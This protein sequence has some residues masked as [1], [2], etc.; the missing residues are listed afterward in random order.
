MMMVKN[1]LFLNLL[2]IIKSENDHKIKQYA[3][4]ILA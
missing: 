3:L 2:L 4:K 1:L